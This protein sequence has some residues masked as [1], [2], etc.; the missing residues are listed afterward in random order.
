MTP[1]NI[2]DA[3]VSFQ[4]NANTVTIEGTLRLANMQEYDKIA[5]YLQQIVADYQPALLYI[6]LAKLLF[7]NSSGITTLSLFVLHCKR[8]TTPNLYIKGSKMVPWQEK[9]LLNFQ[10]LWNNV[11]VDIE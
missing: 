8:N 7:L 3:A 4:Q 1:L 2:G 11:I 10:K 9:S 5:R 6:D